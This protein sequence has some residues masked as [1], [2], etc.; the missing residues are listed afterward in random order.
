[1]VLGVRLNIEAGRFP[2]VSA[3]AGR[4]NTQLTYTDT[5]LHT[6]KHLFAVRKKPF[7]MIYVKSGNFLQRLLF[8]IQFLLNM[9]LGYIIVS[10][11]CNIS[12]RRK[13]TSSSIRLTLFDS[14]C[15]T[16]SSD[17]IDNLSGMA[18][19]NCQDEKSP[20]RCSGSEHATAQHQ[21]SHALWFGT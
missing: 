6:R 17:L 15:K 10:T 7:C 18:Y 16:E 5:S 11:R 20:R 12:T 2:A 3:L 21:N 13:F 4:C 14:I 9:T 1:M 8:V 19:I